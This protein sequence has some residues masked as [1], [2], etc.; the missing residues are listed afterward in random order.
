MQPE[1]IE[2]NRLRLVG[3]E[4]Y[5]NTGGNENFVNMLHDMRAEIKKRL[6]EI[7]NKKMKAG[8]WVSGNF[9]LCPERNIIV[10]KIIFAE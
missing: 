8:T 9:C 10:T 1:R 2:T 4:M 3:V 6:G 7:Q 5:V